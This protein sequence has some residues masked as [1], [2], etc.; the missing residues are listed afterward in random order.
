MGDR[1]VR[2]QL[3]EVDGDTG[4]MLPGQNAREK[5]LGVLGQPSIL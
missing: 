3:A 1:D 5:C 2:P 4:K